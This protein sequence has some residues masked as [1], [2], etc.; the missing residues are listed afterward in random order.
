MLL[1]YSLFG[2]FGATRPSSVLDMFPSVY[3][4]LVSDKIQMHSI[5]YYL[6]SDSQSLIEIV[7]QPLNMMQI[8]N[9]CYLYALTSISKFS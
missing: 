3:M 6:L 4:F 2:L 9:Q 7:C 1:C 8:K 5:A